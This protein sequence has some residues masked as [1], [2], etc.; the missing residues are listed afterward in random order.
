ME[1]TVSIV[2]LLDLP[3]ESVP[4]HHIVVKLVPPR[5]GREFG[6]GELGEWGEVEAVDEAVEGVE[7]RE[8]GGGGEESCVHC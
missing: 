4:Q 7:R 6:A 2:H 8:D 5:R 3:T 1:F